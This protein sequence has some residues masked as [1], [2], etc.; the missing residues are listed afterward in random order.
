MRFRAEPCAL[1]GDINPFMFSDTFFFGT[2]FSTPSF[3]TLLAPLPSQPA[4]TKAMFDAFNRWWYYAI[5]RWY[6]PT[7]QE[8]YT[9]L[10]WHKNDD[11][12]WDDLKCEKSELSDLIT[13]LEQL[14][15]VA[16]VSTPANCKTT[17]SAIGDRLASILTMAML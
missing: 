16:E 5:D 2:L 1:D 10:G 6:R 12:F 4:S 15:Y 3:L 17:W 8:G 9:R 13:R 11:F 14:G 7:L